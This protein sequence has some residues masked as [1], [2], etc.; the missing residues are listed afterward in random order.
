MEL[1]IFGIT[2]ILCF[3]I[4]AKVGQK[5]TKGEDIKLPNVN[6]MEAIR[7][8]QNK[9]EARIEQ[10]RMDTIMRNIEAYDGTGRGQE[11]IPSRK[12]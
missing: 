5:V 7:A 12:G 8:H 9:V 2:N 1:L 4:G 11:D 6:P 3:V 10:D